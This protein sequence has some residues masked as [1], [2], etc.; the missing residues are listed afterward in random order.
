MATSAG[1]QSL[2]EQLT[3]PVC[4][5][6]YT[7]PRTLPC[8]HS[9]CQEC[10]EGLPFRP[11]DQTWRG[12]R[13][14]RRNPQPQSPRRHSINC[15]TCR[16][17]A[18]LPIEEGATSF[19]IA[20]HLNSLKETYELLLQQQKSLE[21]SLSHSQ[22]VVQCGDCNAA[23]SDVFV[24]C[25]ECDKYLCKRCVATHK[26]ITSHKVVMADDEESMLCSQHNKPL[27]VFCETCQMLVCRDCTIR[28][29]RNCDH[30]A[31]SDSHHK[32]CQCL[33]RLL[34]NSE[35]LIHSDL[36]DI[37]AREMKVKNQE[38]V[39]KQEIHTMVKKMIDILQQ[40]ETQLSKE[41]EAITSN[42]L[43]VLA[44]EKKSVE[45]NLDD[46]KKCKEFV[47]QIL[48]S[49]TPREVLMSLNE[50]YQRV[51]ET[52]YVRFD[53]GVEA[54]VIFIKDTTISNSLQYIGTVLTPDILR[55]CKIKAIKN[56][57]VILKE[58]MMSF[59]LK[60]ELPDSSPLIV[61]LSFVHCNVVCTDSKVSIPHYATGSKSIACKVAATA[62]RGIYKAVCSQVIKGSIQL[63]VQI[64]NHH[65]ATISLTIPFN[66]YLDR[67]APVHVINNVN[68][69][70]GV[71]V[72]DD[73]YII[74]SEYR[75]SCI[76]IFNKKGNKI[77]TLGESSTSK[78]FVNP[79]GVAINSENLII[80]VDNHRVQKINISSPQHSYYYQA[81]LQG[82]LRIAALIGTCTIGNDNNSFDD[83]HGIAISHLNGNIY[84]A[85]RDNH[86]IKVLKN[87]LSFFFA[88][89][90]KGPGKGQ[91]KYPYDVAIDSK[92]HVYVADTY[93]H[94]IQKF[95]ANAEFVCQFGT[96]GSGIRQFSY[97]YGI[98]IDIYDMIYI[99]DGGNHRVSVYT[100]CGEYI[101]SFGSRG[102]AMGQ[103]IRPHGLA[104]D[105][106][107]HLYV[108]DYDN[109]RIVVY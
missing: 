103:F 13:G 49:S 109:K 18:V 37:N 91:F 39:V 4:I 15:P 24:F 93:N 106:S 55:R 84:V 72:R 65:S 46:F 100:S 80:V 68:C 12:G 50:I 20:F 78:T 38:R 2:E 27:D 40:T 7:N 35:K 26:E 62:N 105:S 22:A 82:P 6:I 29:H 44:E 56:H 63:N 36:F 58:K 79:H 108:C 42:K 31:I 57:E 41:V 75:S 73:G 32:H 34:K 53:V 76:S 96:E 88:F 45:A 92:G 23:F 102:S 54:D 14:R 99:S 64:N 30:D 10:L 33:N 47:E 9:F 52:C 104:F 90:V 43:Q 86:R 48:E 94:R 61:P 17:P 11:C 85:D 95:I 81:P 97:P 3:C 66:P 107:G 5:D 67:I 28:R 98:T 83:P 69:P 21:E 1:L 8:L 74:A 25:Q 89:G 101:Q 19:P 16:K 71:V 87:N 77:R 51:D 70:W 59:P 60:I